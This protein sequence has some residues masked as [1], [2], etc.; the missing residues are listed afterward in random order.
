M[1]SGPKIHRTDTFIHQNN[2]GVLKE[3]VML[4]PG[5]YEFSCRVKT[6]SGNRAL[7]NLSV[8]MDALNAGKPF[9]ITD[10]EN[11]KK[12]LVDVL[13]HAFRDSGR[14]VGIFDAVPAVLELNLIRD[15]FKLHRD[16]GFD[17][18]I[19]IGG[20]AVMDSAKVLNIA[21]SGEPEDLGRYTG[22][23]R[24][25][26]S[27]NPLSYVPTLSGTGYETS[28]FA[29]LG[30]NRYASHRLMPDLAI[31]DPRMT[32][33][34][35]VRTIAGTSL[36]ALTQSVEAYI[37]PDRNPLIGSYA[38]TSIQ[39]IMENLVEVIKKSRDG[40]RRMALANAHCMAGYVFSNAE[41]GMA[42][43][44]GKSLSDA[45]RI[46]HGLCMGIVLPHVLEWQASLNSEH[47]GDLLMP[48]AG[49]DIYA[50]TE[51]ALRI[52]KAIERIRNM[53]NE[54]FEASN[55]V[56]PRTLKDAGIPDKDVLKDV[57][58][59][60]GGNSKGFDAD[61][62]LTVLEQAWGNK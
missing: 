37:R 51:E 13:L 16:G 57:A 4:L 28:R 3:V 35:D 43:T 48:L 33:P 56:I 22:E 53:Q 58:R 21:V 46:S 2:F 15:M 52:P 31:I 1:V 41:A 45:C 59:Q 9:V 54:L 8:E 5:H 6:N 50:G 62:C 32:I 27:L 25:K 12:G 38:Y 40:S 34:E 7:E 36:I 39:F 19:A 20:G 44:L 47:I 14:T 17:A 60:V 11:S 55:G 42:Y 18:M 10:K 30:D 29:F 61:G 49:F 23:D 26:K 24:I